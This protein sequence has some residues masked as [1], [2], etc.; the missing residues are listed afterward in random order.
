M[1]KGNVFSFTYYDGSNELSS[2]VIQGVKI[3][4]FPQDGEGIT[5][6]TLNTFGRA[7]EE[8]ASDYCG[9]VTNLTAIESSGESSSV[10][11]T[12]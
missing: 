1:I 9:H 8:F 10:T 5:E 11:V 2:V 7:L 6:E 4:G 3:S 12:P